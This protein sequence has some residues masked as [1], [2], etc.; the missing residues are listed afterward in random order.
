VRIPADDNSR[1][2]VK[3]SVLEVQR[4][5]KQLEAFCRRRSARV[6]EADRWCVLEEDGVLT[7]REGVGGGAVLRL[8]FSERRWHLFIPAGG[9]GWRPYPPRPE[10][11]TIDIVIGELD[12]APLHIHW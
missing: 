10:A 3:V 5:R 8:S 7:I 1:F 4:A 6:G 11:E 12:Q 9:G 2:P